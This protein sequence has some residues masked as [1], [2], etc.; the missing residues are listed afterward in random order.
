[1]N[2]N[3]SSVRFVGVALVAAAAIGWATPAH[4]FRMIQ[5]FASGRVTA[6]SLVTCNDPGGFVHWTS[7]ELDWRHN[8]AGQGAGLATAGPSG[9]GPKYWVASVRTSAGSTS[10]ATT[11]VALLGPYHRWKNSFTSAREAALRSA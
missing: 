1:M 11:T 7:A 4:A 5:N 8:T 10:P 6:G 9:M 2:R 3:K